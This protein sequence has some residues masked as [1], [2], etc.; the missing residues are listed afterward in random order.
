MALSV[1]T[2]ELAHMCATVEKAVMQNNFWILR[3]THTQRH[4]KSEGSSITSQRNVLFISRKQ[5]MQKCRAWTS[6]LKRRTRQ[7]VE[8]EREREKKM[9]N[10]QIRQ[11]M[12]LFFF[13]LNKICNSGN[14]YDMTAATRARA[15]AVRA[16]TERV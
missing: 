15:H 10:R 9:Y 12:K 5:R 1:T 14:G 11:Q 6:K 2:Y 4:M 13:C 16:Y 8:E 3:P 7:N